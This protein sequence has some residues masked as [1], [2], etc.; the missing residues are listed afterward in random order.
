MVEIE[1]YLAECNPL[2]LR[3]AKLTLIGEH[4]HL[5]YRA[6]KGESAFAIRMIN[7]E[8]YR[9]GEWI[10]MAEEYAL[11]RA[12]ADT[13]LAPWAYYLGE[14]FQPP[15]LIQEYIQATCFN[16]LKP[17]SV[18][19]LV[20]AARAIAELNSQPLSPETLLFLKKYTGSSFHWRMIVWQ[21]RLA[22]AV[23]RTFQK[24]V[25]AWAIHIL[26]ITIR[27]GLV[28]NH[29]K[30]LFR[31]QPF[32]FHFDGAHTGNTYWKN[33]RAM[34][35][36]WEKVSYRNDPTF[37]LV[38]FMT[39]ANTTEESVSSSMFGTLVGTY[40]QYRPV[41][42]FGAMARARLLERQ[43]SDLVWVLWDYARWG[44]TRPVVEGT[45][46]LSRFEAVRE[47]LDTF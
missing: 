36:D 39:S 41:P 23:R 31:E 33:G 46:V 30:R 13:S 4:N 15:L 1:N 40:Q 22:D 10:S 16:D 29:S 32:V 26:P 24:D 38:R 6:E 8:S 34:F 7:P 47:F 45:S 42:N 12:L 44:D 5:V 28:L 3:G 20:G 25:L 43:V 37:T 18:A 14:D 19:H 11:L 35:L 2:N 21:A 9:A 27:A 17:L